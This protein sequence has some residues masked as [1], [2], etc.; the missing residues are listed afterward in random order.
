MNF[1]DTTWGFGRAILSFYSNISEFLYFY[2]LLVS[3]Q[4]SK[5]DTS[6]DVT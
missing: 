4:K 6:A 2:V 1:K 3:A 5:M